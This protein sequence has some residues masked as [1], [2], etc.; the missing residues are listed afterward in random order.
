MFSPDDYE[1]YVR[2]C[3]RWAERAKSASERDLY[4]AMAQ[5]AKWAALAKFDV[6]S[7]PEALHHRSK[8]LQ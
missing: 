6:L 5:A 8:Y 1:D 2:A 3:E 7:D 4:L